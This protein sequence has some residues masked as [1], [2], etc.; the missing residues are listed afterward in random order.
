MN[1]HRALE[2]YREARAHFDWTLPKTFNFARDVVDRFARVPERPALL[3]CDTHGRTRRFGFGEMS[4]G[5]H[6]FASLLDRLG[7]VPGERLLVLL[8]PLPEWQLSVIGAMA[9]GVLAVPTSIA[10]LSREEILHRAAHSGAVA[11]VTTRSQVPL[12]NS[13]AGDLP[14]LR[15]RLLVR[16]DGDEEAVPEA[17]IDFEQALRS[18]DPEW[19]VRETQ[20]SD[21]ALVL[22]T[23]GTTGRPKAVLHDHGYPYAAARQGVHWHGLRAA[24]RFWPTT[25]WAK[26]AFVPW[27][28][29]AEIV[30]TRERAS[31]GRQL[32]LLA[33]LAPQVFCAPPTQYR[34]MLKEDLSGFRVPQL[35]EC[36]AAGEP[37]NPEVVTA[38]HN[39][40]GLRIRDGYGQSEAGLLV[41]NQVGLPQK[42]GSMGLPLPGFEVE[43]INEREEILAAGAEG[44]LAVRLPAPGV[45]AEYWRDAEATRRSRR[46]A[47]YVTGDRARRDADGYLW[48]IGRADDVI[49]SANQRIGPFEVESRLLE[50]PDV[51]EAAAVAEPDADLGHVVKAW[52]VLRSG[53]HAS[54]ELVDALRQLFAETERD[55]VPA[56]FAF[57]ES[58]PKTATGKIRRKALREVGA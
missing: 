30:V 2:A 56:R 22:Y 35:R 53:I 16:E 10:I 15:H 19:P 46:G 3:Y 40:T 51:V 4:D 42:A 7:L 38:W 23:S 28:C 41:A 47:W 26:A 50:H 1:K 18:G 31:P 11:V 32:E 17:W 20:L 37:L 36:V 14:A 6:R 21:P 48:F 39:A 45:F 34:L 9:A 5:I 49:I 33:E 43:V 52:V 13:L 29:G 58:L 27:S 57:V 24:D 12:I 44:D 55:R 25:G 8:P 54:D